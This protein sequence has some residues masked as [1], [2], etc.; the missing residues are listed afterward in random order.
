MPEAITTQSS[1]SPQQPE[2]RVKRSQ[3]T[4]WAM[5]DWGSAAFNAVMI[6]F[7]FGTYLA[8]ETFGADGRGTSWLAAGNA[9]A[10]VIIALT[11]PVIGQ[12]ADRDGRRSLWLGVNTGFVLL[13][14]AGCFFVQPDES[15]LLLGVILLSAGNVFFEFAEVQYNAMLVKIATKS[16]IG[17]ISGLGWGAGYLG[18]IFLLLLVYVGFI[19][20]DTHWFGVSGDDA[21]NI[22]VV[23]LFAAL[24]FSVFAV[25]VIIVMRPRKKAGAPV[26]PTSERVTIVESYRQLVR[27]IINLWKHQ[28]NTFWFLVSSAVFR[29][30]VGAVFAYGAILGTTVYGVAPGDILFFGIGANVV[31]AA[32]A[33]LG[34]LL[35]DRFGPKKIILVSLVGLLISAIVVFVQDGTVAF[36][37]WG[38]FL[39]FFVGPVQSSS[40]A[41]LG[42][43]TT[44]ESA[45][46]MYGLYATTGRSVSFLTPALI[47]IFVGVSGDSRMMVPAIIIVLLAGL[48]LLWPVRDPKTS[49]T[50]KVLTDEHTD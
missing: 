6:T 43:L 12:R 18:G 7:V 38:L 23:A 34:G 33:F 21:M 42:R 49:E 27:T 46:E 31:A 40:R 50:D 15:F 37:I 39:C 30:G 47:A 44:A 1:S 16:T 17:R 8:S 25:P 4:A 41:F 35:D 2:P 13:T 36:W 14:T 5:W 24:W 48:L 29:D 32:G 22:R 28:R 20:G 45:G 10:G 3:V 11:A 9:I 19:G 26:E